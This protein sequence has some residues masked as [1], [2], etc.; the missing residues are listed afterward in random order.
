MA[1]TVA[2]HPIR[3]PVA[4][5]FYEL[6]SFILDQTDHLAVSGGAG[7][8]LQFTPDDDPEPE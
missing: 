5:T 4:Y 8:R 7:F 6:E 2:R 3:H 1:Q